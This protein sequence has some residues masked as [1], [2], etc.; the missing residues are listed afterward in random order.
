METTTR[1]WL[2]QVG[3][4]LSILVLI[5]RAGMLHL[6]W[7]ALRDQL[8]LSLALSTLYAL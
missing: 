3:E 7:P 8:V 4:A 1:R 6:L 5:A 2:D